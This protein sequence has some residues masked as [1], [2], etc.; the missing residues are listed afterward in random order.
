MSPEPLYLTTLPLIS[1]YP[2]VQVPIHANMAAFR[3]EED[4]KVLR[5]PG[6]CHKTNPLMLLSPTLVVKRAFCNQYP[7]HFYN[8]CNIFCLIL[9]TFWFRNVIHS[10]VG[11]TCLSCGC[12]FCFTKSYALSS[13]V[14]TAIQ[15]FLAQKDVPG[16]GTKL[17]I[18]FEPFLVLDQWTTLCTCHAA[19]IRRDEF[20]EIQLIHVSC[21]C[22]PNAESHKMT[23]GNFSFLLFR[24]HFYEIII[25]VYKFRRKNMNHNSSHFL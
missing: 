14:I 23:F 9:L 11:K 13:E 19:I 22:D 8:P 24:W 6:I 2:L 25:L 4:I 10:R 18:N 16:V 15:L 20:Q 21:L 12:Q 7:S 17:S 5:S 1:L 3:I